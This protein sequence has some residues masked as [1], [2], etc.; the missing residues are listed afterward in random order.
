MFEEHRVEFGDE[1]PNPKRH[2]DCWRNA[3]RQV[4]DTLNVFWRLRFAAC[5]GCLASSQAVLS[6]L[7]LC[8]MRGFHAR[9]ASS[10]PLRVDETK[11]VLVPKSM[12]GIESTLSNL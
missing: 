1:W 9:K 4:L 7:W 12:V 10:R 2:S 11:G 3:V 8:G 5:H 6:M